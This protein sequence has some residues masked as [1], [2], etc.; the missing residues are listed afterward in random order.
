MWEK[1]IGA[2]VSKGNTVFIAAV[3][4]LYSDYEGEHLIRIGNEC[5]HCPQFKKG[6]ELQF[7]MLLSSRTDKIGLMRRFKVSGV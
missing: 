7:L 2:Y 6:T 3:I 4:I 1:E 5:S